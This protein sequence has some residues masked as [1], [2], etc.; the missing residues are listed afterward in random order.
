M[1]SFSPKAPFLSRLSHHIEQSSLFYTVGPRWLS[2]LVIQFILVFVTLNFLFCIGVELVNS[3]VVVSGE[4]RR[5][6]ATQP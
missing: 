5:D 3:V 1:Y 6:S 2:I 4:K